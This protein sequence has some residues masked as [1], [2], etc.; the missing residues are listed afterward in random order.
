MNTRT[1]AFLIVLFF[2]I[3]LIIGVS[4]KSKPLPVSPALVTEVVHDT[5]VLVRPDTIRVPQV[6][7]YTKTDTVRVKDS[8]TV[9]TE[10]CV[11]VPLLLSDSSV[12]SVNGC[13]A[14]GL[15]QD[16]EFEADWIDKRERIRTIDRVRIDTV[17]LQPR[18]LGFTLGP[19]AGVGIDINDISR[20]AYFIGATLTYGWR[21]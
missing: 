21:F 7:Y 16:I 1:I 6:K 17:R 19:S 11:T 3:G 5:V 18:R 12:I 14:I 8:V 4:K 15:P 2:L 20:P 9:K 13:S 10:T